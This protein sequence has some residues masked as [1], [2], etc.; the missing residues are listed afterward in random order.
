MYWW[1]K[2]DDTVLDRTMELLIITI[3]IEIKSVL[4]PSVPP[5]AAAGYR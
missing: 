1:M 5:L 2:K 4:P 3:L